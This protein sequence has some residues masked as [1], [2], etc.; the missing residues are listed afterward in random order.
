MTKVQLFQ[1][2]Q[3]ERMIEITTAS[4]VETKAVVES[5]ADLLRYGQ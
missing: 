5:Q 1:P 2:P 3:I 4:R